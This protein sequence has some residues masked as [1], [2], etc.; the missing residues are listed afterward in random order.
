MTL[1]IT[2]IEKAH[3]IPDTADYLDVSF[4]ITA[5]DD[6]ISYSGRHA[7]PLDT[8]EEDMKRDLTK[9][10]ETFVA[11]TVRSESNEKVE[12]IHKQADE[13]IANLEGHTINA[14]ETSNQ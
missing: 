9:V 7:F 1:T 11:D 6:T 4:E 5:A 12:A 13:T 14:Q 8:P 10:L 2:K 3:S